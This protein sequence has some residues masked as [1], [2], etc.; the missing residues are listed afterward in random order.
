MEKNSSSFREI[1]RLRVKEKGVLVEYDQIIFTKDESGKESKTVRHHT[2]ETNELAH[3]DMIIALG[4]LEEHVV[5]ITELPI[6]LSELVVTGITVTGTAEEESSRVVII[7]KKTIQ[8][9][10]QVV[11]IHTPPTSLM[12]ND[13]YPK[14]TELNNVVGCV[15]DETI[16][17]LDGKH[18]PNLQAEIQFDE[19]EEKQGA[20]HDES[21]ETVE[22][23]DLS[24]AK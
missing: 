8:R 16:E 10:G 12:D 1:K 17:F 5:D 22:V 9:S 14:A 3:I 15:L 21:E 4:D 18:A 6:D 7:S 20:G 24:I 19:P 23:G 13:Q 2:V 11:N